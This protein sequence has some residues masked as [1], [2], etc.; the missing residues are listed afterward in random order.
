MFSLVFTLVLIC[1]RVREDGC[2]F[3]HFSF[4]I[5]PASLYTNLSSNTLQNRLFRGDKKIA[6]LLQQAK[7]Q[8]HHNSKYV[9]PLLHAY[10]T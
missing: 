1:D 6:S 10:Q 9:Q 2:S 4:P 3:V 5:V 8:L 7:L